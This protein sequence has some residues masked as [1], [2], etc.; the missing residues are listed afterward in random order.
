MARRQADPDR[1]TISRVAAEAGVSRATVS[2]SFTHPD[3]LLPATVA[4]VREVAERLGYVPNQVAQALS[5]G[6]AGNIALIVPDIA[7]PFFSALMRGAQAQ[8]YRRGYATF[9]GDTDETEELEDLL[10]GKLAVQVDGFVLASPRQDE[11][12]IRVH[13]ARRPLVVINRDLEGIPRVLVD[14]TVGFA[15]AVNLL[16]DYGHRTIAY[17]GGPKSSWS[18]QQRVRAVEE[19]AAARGLK[20]VRLD[21]VRPSHEAGRDAVEKVLRCGATAAL[22]VDDVVAQGLMAGLADRG[23]SVPA[24]FSLVGCD[25]VIAATTYPPLTTIDAL[26][27]EAGRTA[28]DL[29]IDGLSAE[30]PSERN[31]IR[32][33]LTIR[34]STGPAPERHAAKKHR[35]PAKSEPPDVSPSLPNRT[36]R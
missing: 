10:L 8:A 1:P 34:A 31:V 3:L 19:T 35:S 25:N 24:D 27:A 16:A 17:V 21:A 9:L 32:G 6:K 28:V 4:K 30:P 11:K 26:C 33:E 12:R 29:L 2:R 7:N 13:A 5:T 36:E 14:T 22:A 20:L 18:N 15:Q 23:L